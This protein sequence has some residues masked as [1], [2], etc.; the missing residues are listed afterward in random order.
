MQVA[1]YIMYL[2]LAAAVPVAA[3]SSIAWVKGLGL[4]I[5]L[6]LIDRILHRGEADRPLTELPREGRVNLARFLAPAAFAVVERAYGRAL[7]T[8]RSFLLEAGRA[9]AERAEIKEGLRRLDVDPKE[10]SAK[11]EALLAAHVHVEKAPRENV[12]THAE[13][14]VLGAFSRALAN[15]SRFIG[16]PELFGALASLPDDEATRMFTT[17]SVD[18]GDLDQALVFGAAARR[19]SRLRRLPATLGGFVFESHRRLR[20]RVMN[21]AWTSRP[22]PALDSCSIDFTDLARNEEAGFLI[23]HEG[24]YERLIDTLSRPVNPNALLVGEAG[25]GKETLVAHLAFRIVHDDVP[26]A[27]FDKRLVALELANLVAGAPPEELQKRL[28]N[29][30]EE[31]TTAGNVILYIPD[32]HNLVKTS[33]TAYLSAADALLPIITN[34]AFPLIGATYPRE[35]KEFLEP[36]SDFVGAFEAIRVQEITEAEAERVLI[37]ESLILGK[38]EK[39]TV[40]FGAVKTAVAIAKK[41]FRSRFLPGSAEE[42]LRAG[43]VRAARSGEKFLGPDGIIAAAEEKVNIPIHEAGEREA[44]ALLNLE[45]TIHKRLVDQEEAVQA[46]SNALREYR[47]GLSRAGGPIASFLFVG[48]T[49][50]GKTELSK[51]LAKIQFGSADAM[52]RFDMTEYQDK[53][54]FFRFIGSPDGKI[55]GALTNAVLQAPYSLILLDEFEKAYPDILNLFLQVLDDGRLTD[56]LGRVVDFEHTVIIATSNAHSDIINT[57]LREGQSMA[58]IAEYLKRKL[59]DVFRPELLNRFSKVVVFKDLS[60]ADVRK[61][62]EINLNDLAATLAGQGIRLAFSADVIAYVAKK[63]FDPAFGARPLRRVIEEKLRAPLAEKILK[64]EVARGGDVQA[65]MKGEEIEFIAKG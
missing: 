25:I 19:F 28:Q 44:E 50:V 27:I 62:A 53:Q 10:F 46:V 17:F 41:Y 2:F 23:G 54:S 18:P 7:I 34:N 45:E 8:R 37:Y 52:I 24:E 14:L 1:G 5:L 29:I 22:T 21:R 47:S 9:L 64:K 49:G 43:L 51:I 20:H 55:S 32:I 13:Q 42:L 11:A 65:V 16:T 48:P 31:I 61:I 33:G 57:A 59:T 3:A 39:V 60:P 4:F 36:R 56:N 12:H 26:P 6:F 15:K 58:D 63:G 35:F 40:S 38:K 30:M